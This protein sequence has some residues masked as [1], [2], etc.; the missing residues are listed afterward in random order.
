LL[1]F[2]YDEYESLATV[3]AAA[4]Q[5]EGFDVQSFLYSDEILT[6]LQARTQIYDL[7]IIG[8]G[9]PGRDLLKLCNKIRT[10]QPT[11]PLLLLVSPF[12]SAT[13]PGVLSRNV[14]Y[15]VKPFTTASL[16]EHVRRI[17]AAVEEN[18]QRPKAVRLPKVPVESREPTDELEK[19]VASYEAQE[20]TI[21]EHGNLKIDL[22]RRSVW[23]DGQELSLAPLEYNLLVYFLQHSERVLSPDEL[24][25]YVWGQKYNPETHSATIYN[26]IKNLR[27]KLGDKY[28]SPIYIETVPRQGYRLGVSPI[29]VQEGLNSDGLLASTRRKLLTY[30][31]QKPKPRRSTRLTPPEPTSDC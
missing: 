13:M 16:L 10:Y 22:F 2:I 21:L 26:Y 30:M 9:L 6:D 14:V 7:I 28:D 18:R 12:R 4:L 8:L 15:L 19:V 5:N 20:G 23:K 29:A 3:F 31:A 1:L 24:V 25:Q 17:V 11:T 27:R